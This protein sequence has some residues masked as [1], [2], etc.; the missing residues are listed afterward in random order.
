MKKIIIALVAISLSTGALFAET[1][2]AK[3]AAKTTAPAA[4]TTQAAPAAAPAAGVAAPV[5]QADITLSATISKVLAASKSKGS[6]AEIVVKGADAK[7]IVLVVA[8]AS[9]LSNAAGK[10]VKLSALK[11][12]EAVSVVYTPGEKRNTLVS[13]ALSK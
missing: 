1:A 9:T 8:K 12:G 6:P 5:A 3:T 2:A 13:L 4:T 7:K 11:A 10:A